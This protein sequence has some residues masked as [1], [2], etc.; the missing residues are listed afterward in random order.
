VERPG[1]PEALET[2]RKPR[3]WEM[4]VLLCPLKSS[5]DW[6]YRSHKTWRRAR[7]WDLSRSRSL[8]TVRASRR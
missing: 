1:D 2:F 7:G 6:G 5:F 3:S 4:K 8:A